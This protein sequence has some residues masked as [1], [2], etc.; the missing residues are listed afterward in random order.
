MMMMIALIGFGRGELS[1]LLFVAAGAHY[2]DNRIA[3]INWPMVGMV[4]SHHISYNH[5]LSLSVVVLR[6]TY[7]DIH[8]IAKAK[9]PMVLLLRYISLIH[10]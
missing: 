4:I 5:H 6:T 10:T 1:R 3:E 2:V 9:D 8:V 7:F